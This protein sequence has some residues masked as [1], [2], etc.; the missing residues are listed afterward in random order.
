LDYIVSPLALICFYLFFVLQIKFKIIKII[1]AR[2]I[3]NIFGVNKSA[4]NDPNNKEDLQSILI[5][6]WNNIKKSLNN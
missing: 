3:K 4:I 5:Q 1:I 2:F 6:K